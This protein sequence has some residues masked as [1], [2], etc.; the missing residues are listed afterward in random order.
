MTG[1]KNIPLELNLGKFK[2]LMGIFIQSFELHVGKFCDS[3][4]CHKCYVVFYI[5]YRYQM[6]SNVVAL[7]MKWRKCKVRGPSMNATS[8][9]R[10]FSLRGNTAHDNY[11]VPGNGGVC[12][13]VCECLG[14]EYP[15][16]PPMDCRVPPRD[17]RPGPGPLPPGKNGSRSSQLP[18]SLLRLM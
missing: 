15:G 6:L 9:L 13:G 8:Q 17:P 5:Q 18:D 16:P 1:N 14:R 7:Y 10:C 3:V 4:F 11:K 2:I 12:G